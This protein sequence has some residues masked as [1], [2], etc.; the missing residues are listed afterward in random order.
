MNIG[1]V[2]LIIIASA[3]YFVSSVPTPEQMIADFDA[4]QTLYASAAYDQAIEKYAEVGSINSRFVDEDAVVVSIGESN[5]RIKDATQFQTANSY[6]LMAELEIALE[7]ESEEDEKEEHQ[8]LAKEYIQKANDSFDAVQIETSNDELKELAQKLIQDT[9][10]LINDYDRV[11]QEGQDLIE[12]YPASQYVEDAL[13]N[14]G[15]AYYDDGKYDEAIESFDMLINRFPTGQRA[16][17]SLFQIGESYFAKEEYDEAIP[18]YQRLVDKMRINELTELEILK[19]QREKSAGLV[20]DTALDRAARAALR[21]GACYGNAGRYSEAEESYKRMARLF[22]YDSNLIYAAYTSLADM[23]Y[24]KGQ[25][26]ESIDAYNDAIDEVPDRIIGAKMQIQKAQR[27][28]EGYTDSDGESHTYY[29]EAIREFRNYINN[30]SEVAF[31]AGYDLDRAYFDL[32]RSYYEYGSSLIAQGQDETG[33]ENLDQA[34]TTYQ[35]IFE[36]FPATQ[37]TQQIYFY[38]AMTYQEYE[39]EENTNT[40][41]SWYD[42][43]LEEYPDTP[44]K[45]YVYIK[46]GRAYNSVKDYENAKKYYS[47]FIDEYPKNDSVNAVW[48]ELGNNETDSGNEIDAVE[49][50]NNVSRSNP[51]LFTVAR[52]MSA[53]TLIRQQMFQQAIEVLDYALED[54]S[55]IDSQKRLSQLYLMRGNAHSSLDQSEDALKDYTAAYNLNDPDTQQ[56]AAVFRATIYIDMKQY[57]RAES[58]LRELM[59]NGDSEIQ[60]MSQ[61][62]L[63]YILVQQGKSEQAVQTYLDLYNDTEDKDEKLSYLRNLIQLTADDKNWAQLTNFANQMIE[64]DIAE[65]EKPENQEFYY[66]EEAYYMLGDAAE[67]QA[68]E[69]ESAGD[70]QQAQQMYIEAINYY[71]DG[72]DR[73]PD[74]FY[75]SDMLLKVGVIYL[76]KMSSLSDALD[77]SA[78]AFSQF[79][80]HFPDSPNAEM[81]NYYLGFCYYYGRRFTDANETFRNFATKYQNS[82]FTPEAIFYY[83]EGDYNLGNLDA[84]I[85]GFNLLL[86]RYP[87]HEKAAEALYTRAWCYLDMEQSDNAVASF[88]ELVDEFPQSE[89]APTALFSIADYYYNQQRY[90]D[91]IVEYQKVLDEYPDSDVA[92]K[93]PETLGDLLETA[94]YIE[95]EPA[96]TVFASARETDDPN[97]YNQ[98]IEV[99]SAVAEKY[100]GTQSEIGAISNMGMCYE[101]LY[102]WQKAIEMYDKIIEKFEAGEAVDTDALNFAQSHKQY[103]VA[104]ML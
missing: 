70:E 94:A 77:Q 103:I 44:Y 100:P 104:N 47:L 50:Y 27:Y 14:I 11:I 74:S 25:F 67:I 59:E 12:K 90:D 21:I 96:L 55:A 33:R 73:F 80:E 40:A 86:R 83:S 102:Q 32:G 46:L 66:K 9:W 43:L 101:A 98:A 61:L 60:R 36:D 5:Y 4:A 22:T 52:L 7:D 23:Y 64:S 87:T 53:Q 6:R 37:I 29:V 69:Y 19:I 51:Q 68:A 88:Q 10:Y 49:Y 28:L 57:D 85:E 92:E 16:D 18:Y 20:D 45:Q 75:S 48:F 62:R 97:L 81:A 71:V 91:A 79:I 89:F 35:S 78:Q 8:R 2:F 99:F 82:E 15:W 31:R 38:L 39:I 95:Y 26:T 76:M 3:A 63:A 84:A 17:Q 93:V 41:I 30:Y 13:Y 34:I 58:D 56:T 72:F 54:V 24:E 42:K 1:Y 65:G